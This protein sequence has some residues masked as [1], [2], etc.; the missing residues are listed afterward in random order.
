M[1]RRGLQPPGAPGRETPET[2]I[3]QCLKKS[4]INE[5]PIIS[6]LSTEYSKVLVLRLRSDNPS[7]PEQSIM[8]RCLTTPVGI[9]VQRAA[10]PDSRLYGSIHTMTKS[11]EDME[12]NRM[13]NSSTEIRWKVPVPKTSDHHVSLNISSFSLVCRTWH[14]LKSSAQNRHR[15]RPNPLLDRRNCWA[16]CNPLSIA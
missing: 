16:R 10:F 8:R 2:K 11:V 7:W 6:T 9:L 15:P 14:A 1:P 3:C 12:G 4:G 5:A 13:L